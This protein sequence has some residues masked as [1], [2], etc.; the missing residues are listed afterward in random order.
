MSL[1]TAIEVFFSLA[2]AG[3]IAAALLCRKPNRAITLLFYGSL[4]VSVA[5]AA[6]AGFAPGVVVAVL[7]AGALVAMM[8]VWL[9]TFKEEK[10]GGDA[11]SYIAVA[12]AAAL[13]ALLLGAPHG[14]SVSAAYTPGLLDV[15]SLVLALAVASI[16]IVHLLGGEK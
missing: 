5:V 16:G 13:T 8:L 12:L 4:S 10:T 3:L 2:G 14:P 11:I 7:Y 15:A 9:V 6:L 1:P